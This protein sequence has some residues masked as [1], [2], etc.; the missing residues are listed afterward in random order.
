MLIAC[1]RGGYPQELLVYSGTREILV[2]SLYTPDGKSELP[3]RTVVRALRPLN[4]QA[5]W[6]LPG[7][8][9]LSCDEFSKIDRGYRRHMPQPLRPTAEC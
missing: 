9:R 8:T 4:A 6:P 5:A 3:V 2:T 1:D 7:P